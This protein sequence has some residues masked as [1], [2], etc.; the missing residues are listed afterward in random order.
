MIRDARHKYFI[1]Q[2]LL[3]LLLVFLTVCRWYSG[4]WA[5]AQQK[6]K[7]THNLSQQVVIN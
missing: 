1:L 6:H 2:S 5:H 4:H 7:E 3:L